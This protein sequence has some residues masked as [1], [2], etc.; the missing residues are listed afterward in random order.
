MSA[1]F[2]INGPIIKDKSSIS[3]SARR[4]LLDLIIA[5]IAAQR[6]KGFKSVVT[7]NFGDVEQWHNQ[8]A[9]FTF[10]NKTKHPVSI[11]PLFNENDLDVSKGYMIKSNARA[12][13]TMGSKLGMLNNIS[14]YNYPDN[15]A[16]LR[17]QG[18]KYMTVEDVKAL[19][20]KYIN[21]DEM[22]YLVV[23][24][25]KTQLKKLNKLGFGEPVLLNPKKELKD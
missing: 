8:P 16:K 7:Y 6:D 22:I 1:K 24:D 4:T 5:P 19:A 9:I 2:S 11:L 14:N 25:A 21:P 10:T 3:V 15:Y 12:F 20:D 18:V 13:E 23:G 17:E